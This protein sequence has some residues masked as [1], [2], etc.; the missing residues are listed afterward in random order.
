MRYPQSRRRWRPLRARVH[1]CLGPLGGGLAG[2]AA[3][4]V[5]PDAIFLILVA[6]QWFM[7]AW[8]VW[9]AVLYFR[10]FESART[11]ARECRKVFVSAAMGLGGASL[12]QD[13]RRFLAA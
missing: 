13:S 6:S 4:Q 7:A 1:R 9:G 11:C 12:M 3:V 10:L 8:S 5:F 2:L